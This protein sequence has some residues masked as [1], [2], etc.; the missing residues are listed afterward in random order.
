MLLFD[1][2]RAFNF[3]SPEH[4]AIPSSTYRCRFTKG[5]E[6]SQHHLITQV[7]YK[8]LKYPTKISMI[9]MYMPE[10]RLVYTKTHKKLDAI[11]W[12]VQHVQKTLA[13]IPYICSALQVSLTSA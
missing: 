8:L 4:A 2:S 6:H 3:V 7:S 1:N 9:I 10:S 12:P 13:T 5:L 11:F